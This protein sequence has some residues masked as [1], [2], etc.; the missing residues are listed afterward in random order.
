M[1]NFLIIPMGGIGKR[2]VD[3]G[4]K[5]YKPFLPIDSNSKIIDKITDNFDKKNT[6]IIFIGNKKKICRNNSKKLI[7]NFH[8]IEIDNHT[9]GPLFSIFLASDKLKKIVQNNSLFICYSDINWKWDYK[10]VLNFVKK[11]R[12]VVFTHTGFHP[13][14][15]VDKNSD[16]CAQNKNKNIIAVSEKKTNTKNYSN[17]MLAIGCYYF[18]NLNIVEKFTKKIDFYSNK[19]KEYYLISLINILIKNKI[20]IN[21]FLVSKF[22]HLGTPAQYQDYLKWRDSISKN[23]S[24]NLKLNFTNIMLMGGKGARVK[25]LKQK[26]PF[27]KIKNKKIYQYIFKKFGSYK[28]II[29]SNKDYVKQISKRFK[30]HLIKKTNSMLS[31]I[32]ESQAIFEKHNNFFLTSCDCYGDFQTTKFKQLLNTKKIDLIVFGYKFSNLQKYLT[33]SHTEL[34]IKNSKITNIKVKSSS[35][36]SNIGHAGFFWIKSNKIFKYISRFK[37]TAGKKISKSR[38]LIIDDYFSYLLKNKLFNIKYFML[39]SYIHIGSEKEFNE[40]NYWEKYFNDTK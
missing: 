37:S 15:E 23:W 28:N 26:K 6:E 29:I 16:F 3:A 22:V 35:K 38:E 8:F 11:K 13:H 30:V 27:L 1:K 12:M 18:N 19:K 14:L 36:K 39:D 7:K 40:F 21:Q 20:L 33:N 32:E 34:I 9:K 2:F 25:K 24:I 10:K 5:T 4:Y 31:T 17:E